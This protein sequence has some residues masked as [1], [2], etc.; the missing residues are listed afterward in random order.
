MKQLKVLTFCTWTSIGSI[1]QSFGLKKA[2]AE[3]GCESTILL[4]ADEN[5]YHTT[6][7]RSLKSLLSR[8][9]QVAIHR[10]RRSAYR[11]RCAFIARELDV[12]T[13]EG[14]SE[15]E[16][17]TQDDAQTCYLAG[18]DQIW[19]PNKCDKHFFLEFVRSGKCISYAA[20]MGKTEIPPENLDN[21]RK[22]MQRLDRISVREAQCKEVL[23]PLTDK[24]IDVHIDPTFLLDTQVWRQYEQEYPIRGP[25]ILLYMI[26]WDPACKAQIRE[27]K[28]RTGLPVYAVCSALSRVYAD[29]R[30]FDVGVEEFLWLVD[31]AEYVITSSFHGAALSTI[32]NKKFAA[33]I[34][35]AT[36]SRIRNLLQTLGIPEVPIRELDGPERFDYTA[37][38][39]RMAQERS[40]GLLYLKEAI[41]Q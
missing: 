37:I 34:N 10:K 12:T 15:L 26:Y 40:K 9:H 36:P 41:N 3:N 24:P 20:S 23:Q 28:Q 1:L 29:K 13:Y 27:L 4:P 32:F 21:F 35:P 7:V 31:H 33:V 25:Y 22:L 16:Q 14:Y 17:M 39:K 19:N 6:K 30:L 8:A 5:K 2:L 11:K 38:Q 18:S